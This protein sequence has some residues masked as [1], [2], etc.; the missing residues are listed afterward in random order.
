MSAVASLG[1]V[2]PPLVTPLHECLYVSV[3]A[4]LSVSV[5]SSVHTITVTFANNSERDSSVVVVVVVV[6]IAIIVV[7]VFSAKRSVKTMSRGDSKEE[8]VA[9]AVRQV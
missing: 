3:V 6:V 8:Q 7:C 4:T 2:T 5:I 1:W 9:C